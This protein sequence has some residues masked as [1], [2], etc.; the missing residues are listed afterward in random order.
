MRYVEI[1]IH[2]LGHNIRLVQQ[3]HYL[4]V[5]SGVGPLTPYDKASG[6]VNYIVYIYIY[7]N[8]YK[9]LQRIDD[10]STIQRSS[11]A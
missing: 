1:N 11:H 9:Q 5:G 6:Y 4:T 7:V 10:E 8:D 3:C 2:E